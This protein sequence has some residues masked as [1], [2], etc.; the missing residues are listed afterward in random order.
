MRNIR[1]EKM[2]IRLCEKLGGRGAEG[3]CVTLI[4]RERE[5]ERERERER[6]TGRRKG[7]REGGKEGRWVSALVNCLALGI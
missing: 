5:I 4:G 1:N 6:E 2:R 3:E 7:R